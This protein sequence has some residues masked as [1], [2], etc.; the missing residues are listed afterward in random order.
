MN[1]LRYKEHIWRIKFNT[2]CFFYNIN[3]IQ[4]NICLVKRNDAID[5]ILKARGNE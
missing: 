5:A 2:T 4:N 1:F 3:N